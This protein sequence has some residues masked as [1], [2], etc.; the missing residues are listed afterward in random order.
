[1][2]KIEKIEKGYLRCQSCNDDSQLDNISIGLNLNST[3]SFRLCGMCISIF[4]K[5]IDKV[6][7]EK[8]QDQNKTLREAL[9]FYS[10][11]DDWNFYCGCCADGSTKLEKDHGKLAR[12][13]LAK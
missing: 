7:I 9:E 10:T 2:I 1:M 11:E 12:E 8:L 5:T 13:A 3:S 4:S 6:K